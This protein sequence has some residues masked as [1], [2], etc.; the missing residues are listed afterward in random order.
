MPAQTT[1]FPSEENHLLYPDIRLA[2]VDALAVG[3]AIF[4][5]E[6]ESQLP[7]VKR[8]E[9][10][11]R[12]LGRSW[13]VVGH[14]RVEITGNP[15]LPGYAWSAYITLISA[16]SSILVKLERPE[17]AVL[18]EESPGWELVGAARYRR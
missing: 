5:P 14:L 17:I 8:P 1:A 4:A 13:V 10:C 7:S 2:V 16:P 12:D 18:V 15:V 11:R 9:V 6:L 3:V